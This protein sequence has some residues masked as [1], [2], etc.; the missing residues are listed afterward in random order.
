MSSAVGVVKRVGARCQQ[1]IR[2]D[3]PC[4]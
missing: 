2:R 4:Y 3:A 1:S